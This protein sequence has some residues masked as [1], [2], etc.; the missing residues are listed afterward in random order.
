MLRP[1]LV[2]PEQA[3]LLLGS[4]EVV[5][6]LVRAG[7]LDPVM[8]EHRLVLYAYRHLENCVK[9]LEFGEVPVVSEE[10]K[11]GGSCRMPKGDHV[12]SGAAFRDQAR[13]IINAKPLLLRPDEASLFVG[14]TSLLEEF[15]RGGWIKPLYDR[16]RLVLFSVRQLEGCVGRLEVG[17]KPGVYDK[18][19]SQ[20]AQPKVPATTQAIISPIFI[21]KARRTR[22]PMPV[23]V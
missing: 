11:R 17:E 10:V 19:D 21:R 3:A 4:G 5:T 7:W 13:G 16:H 15:R 9:R 14:C 20:P 2:R 6:E 18:P 12:S 8:S 1:L 22:R 23:G